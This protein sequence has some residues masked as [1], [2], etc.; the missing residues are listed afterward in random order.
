MHIGTPS[1]TSSSVDSPTIFSVL[2]NFFSVLNNLNDHCPS[3]SANSQM[4]TRAVDNLM[5]HVFGFNALSGPIYFS[6][7][8]SATLTSG[9]ITGEYTITGGGS[10]VSAANVANLFT[11]PSQYFPSYG[12]AG[13]PNNADMKSPAD[14]LSIFFRAIFGITDSAYQGLFATNPIGQEDSGTVLTTIFNYVLGA[15]RSGYQ[16]AA[17]GITNPNPSTRL[18]TCKFGGLNTSVFGRINATA[19]S[20]LKP[21]GSIT[22]SASAKALTNPADYFAFTLQKYPIGTE[23]GISTKTGHITAPSNAYDIVRLQALIQDL[24]F[25]Q[26]YTTTIRDTQDQH[27]NENSGQGNGDNNGNNG[28]NGG[29]KASLGDTNASVSN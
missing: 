21:Y 3:T 5:D 28:N 17:N 8:A 1:D 24:I 26:G 19:N 13:R 18:A 14:K 16:T 11:L 15:D 7:T 25:V 27:D 20:S 4:L 12:R 9:S 10:G 6:G 2:N 22:A 29:N 23:S